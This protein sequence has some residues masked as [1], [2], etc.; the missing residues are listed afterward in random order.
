MYNLNCQLAQRPLYTSLSELYG[1]VSSI[2]LDYMVRELLANT[3][4]QLVTETTS[5]EQ[6]RTESH[7]RLFRQLFHS[8][9]K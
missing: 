4:E 6:A 9:W 1:L 3:I 5:L 8:Y 7:D 2:R